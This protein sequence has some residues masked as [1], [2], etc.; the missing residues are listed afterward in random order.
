MR[1]REFIT[2]I[3]G[4]AA[5]PFKARAQ[6]AGRRYRL[7]T[8]GPL[9]G[10]FFEELGRAGFVT[11]G[12]LEIDSNGGAAAASYATVASGLAHA[13][14]DVL[15]VIGTEA[16]R[17][18]QKATQRIPIVAIAD[19]LI[20]SRLVGSMSRPDGNTTG[21]A[22]FAFQ[23]DSK[24]LELLHEAF[25]SARR[26]A[27]LA[28]REPIP[29]MEALESAAKS[30]GVEIIPF[31][32]RSEEN[33][34]R[35]IDAMKAA[36]ADAVNLLASPILSTKFQHLIRDHL[37]LRRL[38]A[39][40]QWP[41]QAEDGGLMGYGPRI[42]AVFDQCARQVAKLLGGAK[43]ADVPVEQPIKFELIIN[44]KT[45][46]TLSVEIPQTLLSRADRTVE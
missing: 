14:P 41:E 9:P 23:L 37:A 34:I 44:L 21:V 13:H 38:P 19:D 17:A 27:V 42:N 43:V 45:A 4:T 2:L 33:L 36:K 8:L 22:I 40:W 35:A 39:I 12:N 3:G 24:R 26:I 20:G 31:A 1:R 25:P 32:A 29:N 46:K 11:G 30:F 18:A 5:W 15:M 16:A 6:K 28:D 7:A 10:S